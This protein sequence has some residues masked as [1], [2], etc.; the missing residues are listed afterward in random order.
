MTARPAPVLLAALLAAAAPAAA[1]GPW[2][3]HALS[4][5]E[6]ARLAREE[7]PF[8]REQIVMLGRL[9]AATEGAVAQGAG[10]R[11]QARR[12]R[13]RLEPG[14]AAVP[15]EILL[16]RGYT[17]ALS[18]VDATG[19]PWPIEEVLVDGRFLPAA[20][21]RAEGARHILYLAP[22]ERLLHGN[23]VVKLHGLAR[24]VTLALVAGSGVV[25]FHVD[26]RM[27]ASGPNADPASAAAPR[28]FHA[29]DPVLLDLLAG[30]PPEGAAR[31][32]LAG[33]APGDGAW[34]HDGDLL[35]VTRAPLLSPA[36]WAAE[37]SADG[38]W[39]WRL[40]ETPHALAAVDGREVRLT[41]REAEAFE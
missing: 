38:R 25:D 12:S 15:P 8:T 7:L 26:V 23:A 24:P 36:P 9:L 3:A 31:L 33:G 18:F 20:G 14:T 11:P 22:A 1:D 16:E 35:V 17:T 29:G 28:T 34:L 10:A 21:E 30:L 5:D 27:A 13:L 39:A 19:E 32:V 40:P 37:R 2:A 41:F 4:D 6:A